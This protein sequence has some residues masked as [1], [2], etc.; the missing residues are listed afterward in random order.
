VSVDPSIEGFEYEPIRRRY[1]ERDTILYA[2]GVGAGPRHDELRFVFEEGL[3][4]LPT[5]PVVP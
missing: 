3:Q 5:F 4:A 2:L 1:D